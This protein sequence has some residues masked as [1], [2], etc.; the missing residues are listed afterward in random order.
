MKYARMLLFALLF[1]LT[2]CTQSTIADTPAAMAGDTPAPVSVPTPSPAPS[3][4]ATPAAPVQGFRHPVP[5]ISEMRLYPDIDIF[6]LAD[7]SLGPVTITSTQEEVRQALGEPDTVANHP[8]HS[9][10][11]VQTYHYDGC[12]IGFVWA[13]DGYVMQH[14]SYTG[15]DLKTPRDIGIGSPVRDTILAYAGQIEKA[16]DNRAIFYRSNAGSDSPEAVPPSGI[17]YRGLTATEWILQF[18]I[19]VE[20]NPYAGYTQAQIEEQYKAMPYYTLRLTTEHGKVTQIDM[21]MGP[22]TE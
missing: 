13:E 3:P 15:E 18:S 1:F 7:L 11:A 9:S 2:A 4:A 20:A 19:P 8:Y 10:G 12:R 6:T 5:Y 17:M 22:Y 16:M 14:C 21:I